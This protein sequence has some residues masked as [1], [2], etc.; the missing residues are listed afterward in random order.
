M[1][2]SDG[3]HPTTEV[4]KSGNVS[5]SSGQA[6]DLLCAL[7]YLHLA[8]GQGAQCVALLR[9]IVGNDSQDVDL[10]RIL[11]YA[12]ISEGLGD[13]ALP[14]LDRLDTLDD[15]P[16]SRIPLM[17]LRSHALRRAGRMDEARAAFQNYVS[18]RAGTV[19]NDQRSEGLHDQRP[20]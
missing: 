6:R 5:L 7:S 16:S 3:A 17:L 11:A 19:L 2:I 9:L 20:A 13:E 4:S 10:L 14:I 1:V 18:L 8:C 12:L 15:D